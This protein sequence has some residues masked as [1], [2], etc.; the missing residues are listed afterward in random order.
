M[1][2]DRAGLPRERDDEVSWNVLADPEGNAVC[3]F[4]RE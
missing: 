3:V 1:L 2:A 4:P